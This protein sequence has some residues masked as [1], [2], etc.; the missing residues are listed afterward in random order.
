VKLTTQYYILPPVGNEKHGRCVHKKPGA[1]DW[2]VNPDLLVKMTP[3]QIEKSLELRQDTDIIEEWK[4]EKD[5]KPR[6]D[7]KDLLSK[8]FD[9]QLEMA[10]LILQ[11]RVLKDLDA[12][13]MAQA[14]R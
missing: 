7:P 2:G 12:E 13:A 4:D 1:E 11:A 8:N 10:L 6:P 3:E 9:P 14:S 5:R